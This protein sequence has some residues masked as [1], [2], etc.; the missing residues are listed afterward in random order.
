MNKLK[1]IRTSAGL[2]CEGLAKMMRE[3]YPK[4]S[5]GHISLAENTYY[6]GLMFSSE[7]MK[8]CREVTGTTRVEHR[9]AAYRWQFRVTKAFDSEL[10]KCMK[11]EGYTEKNAFLNAIVRDYLKRKAAATEAVSDL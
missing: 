7:A 5:K 1:A 2:S 4:M 8:V 10:N 9:K 3:R 11:A 6:T